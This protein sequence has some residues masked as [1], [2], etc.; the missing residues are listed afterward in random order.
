LDTQSASSKTEFKI[1][2]SF[3][4]HGVFFL[5]VSALLFGT[6]SSSGEFYGIPIP[7]MLTLSNVLGTIAI[8]FSAICIVATFWKWLADHLRPLLDRDT[9]GSWST[10]IV[11]YP[12]WLVFWM[13]YTIG[14]LKALPVIMDLANKPGVY[15]VFYVGFLWFLIIPAIWFMGPSVQAVRLGIK[16]TRFTIRFVSNSRL[17]NKI[18]R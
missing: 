11:R 1:N 7:P 17:W 14:W 12:Y 3:I 15:A 5:T 6:K 10:F 9:Q 13:V 16:T 18:F 2:A 8:V 4:K